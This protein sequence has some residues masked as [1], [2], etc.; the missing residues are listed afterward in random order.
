[1]LYTIEI[2]AKIYYIFAEIVL[3]EA[4]VE[5]SYI[6]PRAANQRLR[7]SDIAKAANSL[8]VPI[9]M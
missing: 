6:Q 2:S 1:L 5:E 8:S 3:K 4:S 9:F 7:Q